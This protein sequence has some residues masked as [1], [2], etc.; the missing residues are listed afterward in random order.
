MMQVMKQLLFLLNK[1]CVY[2]SGFMLYIYG[3]FIQNLYL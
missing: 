1:Y 3:L 2:K